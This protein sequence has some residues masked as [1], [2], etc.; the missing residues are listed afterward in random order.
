MD[1]LGKRLARG[2]HAAFAE[3]YDA[4]ADRIHHYLMIILGSKEDAED[5]LQ[6][7]FVRL[8]GNC[9]RLAKVENLTAYTF[10]VARN[11][12]LRLA[13]RR[14]NTASLSMTIQGQ[15]LF[16]IAEKDNPQ[17][18]D[19]VEAATTALNRLDADLREIVELKFF[20]GLTFREIADVTGCPQGTAATRYRTALDKMRA[21]LAK[22]WT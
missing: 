6:E 8:A 21:I 12:A 9:K 7:T 13:G 1:T 3:L 18:N 20:A 17:A 4:C 11:E 19:C 2:D 15:H 10:T 14:K 5:A 22:D 16:D